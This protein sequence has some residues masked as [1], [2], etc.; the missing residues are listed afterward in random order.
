MFAGTF[1]S[2]QS[3]QMV[4]DAAGSS[5]ATSTMSAPSRSDGSNTRSTC[6]I[7]FCDTR[8][9]TSSFRPDAGQ[10]TVTLA[11]ALR[12]LRIRPAATWAC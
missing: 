11:S 2:L 3:F 12:Q 9:A 6:V 1:F 8:K 4:V 5:M 7:C 10:T